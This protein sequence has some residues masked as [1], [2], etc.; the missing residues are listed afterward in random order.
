MK[1]RLLV[2]FFTVAMVNSFQL[3]AQTNNTTAGG[4]GIIPL[5]L[6]VKEG[7]GKFILPEKITIYA[8]TAD[9]VNVN[10]GR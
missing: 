1:S 4:P 7:T 3:F 6:E 10:H 2:K 8:K 5:P 9:E